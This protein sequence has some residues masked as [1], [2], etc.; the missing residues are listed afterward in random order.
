MGAILGPDEYTQTSVKEA[1]LKRHSAARHQHL[2]EI[3]GSIRQLGSECSTSRVTR[4]DAHIH[5]RSKLR[6]PHSVRGMIIE[7][8]S[9]W[10]CP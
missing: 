2:H 3:A 9:Y 8:H 1:K 6:K 4:I 10:M 5:R 7:F